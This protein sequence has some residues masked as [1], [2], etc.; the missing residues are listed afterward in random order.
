MD[1]PSRRPTL[2]PQLHRKRLRSFTPLKLLQYGLL[3]VLAA[4]SFVVIVM[5]VS[6]SLRPTALIYVDFW[7]LPLPPT[8]INYQLAILDL[9]PAM[10]RTLVITFVSIVG[11]LVLACPAAYALA[12]VRFPGRDLV[13]YM[14][15]GVLII[16]GAIL[17]TPHFVLAN[18]LGLRGSM[19]GLVVFYIAGGQP[20]AIFLL[21]TFFRSQIEELFEAARLDGT[22]ELQALLYIA[23]P[24]AW[25]ILVT[26]AIL[27]FLGIYDDYIWPSL[28][29]PQNQQT[30]I[31]ALES[32]NPST[33][34]FTSRPDLGAQTAG[35]VIA[36]LP[37]LLLFSLGMK[38]FVQGLMS[39]SVKG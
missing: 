9:L 3:S 37:Q 13:Y 36:T 24:L 28:M 16:P 7:R 17:L 32:Y 10:L 4:L 6:M 38:Y 12:R 14:V 18:Q 2:A 1:I 15:L 11:I 33:G 39:G 35:Y 19:L 23:V 34:Q 27:N 5:M 29:L 20:F 21:V 31:L 22:S 26:V 8:L 30:L 25:P